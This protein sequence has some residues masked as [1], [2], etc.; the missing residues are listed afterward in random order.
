M[1]RSITQ[2]VT[3]SLSYIYLQEV[4]SHPWHDMD[5][6]LCA[7]QTLWAQQEVAGLAVHSSYGRENNGEAIAGALRTKGV[8][9]DPSTDWWQIKC[10]SA[11]DH[12]SF[13][14]LT[15]FKS[16]GKTPGKMFTLVSNRCIKK[17][18]AK[19]GLTI[20][21]L[22]NSGKSKQLGLCYHG[23]RA[24]LVYAAQSELRMPL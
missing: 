22:Q 21:L 13:W 8:K 18:V 14:S 17:W 20:A 16:S 10:L 1:N 12:G 4:S 6:D 23:F 5:V 7:A 19:K 9:L 2:K 15:S 24:H 11:I 3:S